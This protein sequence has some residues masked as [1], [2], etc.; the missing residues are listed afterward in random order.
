MDLMTIDVTDIPSSKIK[1]GDWVEL[2]GDNLSIDAVAEKAGT[3]PW[4][5]LTSL[6]PRY[7]RFY[8]SNQHEQEVA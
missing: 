2:F 1:A 6:G 4:E 7:E 5:L 8:L 3:V